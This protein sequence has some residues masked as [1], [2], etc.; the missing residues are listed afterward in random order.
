[1]K[2]G[3][4][5]IQHI[6][7]HRDGIAYDTEIKGI[8]VAIQELKNEEL[9]PQNAELTILE[10]GKTSMVSVRLFDVLKQPRRSDYVIN[11][12]VGDHYIPNEIDAYLCSTGR[13]FDH[14]GN[15]K[16]R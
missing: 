5:T 1:M 11:P 8:K 2:K 6:V 9:L 7:V 14:G 3:G 12:Q 10:I 15:E 4:D 13:A 16:G